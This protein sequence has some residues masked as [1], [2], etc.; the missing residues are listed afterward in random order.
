MASTTAT[1]PLGRSLSTPA[2]RAAAEMKLTHVP[3]RASQ[4]GVFL[5]GYEFAPTSLKPGQFRTE[6]Q[7]YTEE[8]KAHEQTYLEVDLPQ[9]SSYH[10]SHSTCTR[11]EDYSYQKAIKPG[12]PREEGGHRGVA[13]WGSNYKQTHS[14]SAIAGAGY[15][16]QYG[17]AC[18]ALNPPTCVSG[19]ESFSSYREDYGEYG[20]DP[21][22]RM[23]PGDTSIPVIR[24]V[25]TYGTPKGTMHM[26]GYQGFLPTN[27]ANPS[28]ARVEKG[29]DLRSTD[30]S[31]LTQTFH[32]N[33]VNY[34]GH[35]PINA[36]NDK[37]GVKAHTLTEFG[38]SFRKP[39]AGCA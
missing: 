3:K 23:A 38:R 15:H 19:A 5:P 2:L 13:H 22:N 26:P 6:R 35:I 24:N 10:R 31:N 34:G 33:L 8:A 39:F 37:G 29:I 9:G 21:R 7:V 14:K 25:L 1:V 30:K 11:P 16:R 32:T 4:H 17:P 12:E 18:Q 36:T 20:S 27:T 28:V